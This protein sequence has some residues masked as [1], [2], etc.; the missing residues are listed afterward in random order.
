[1]PSSSPA[2]GSQKRKAAD[3]DDDTSASTSSSARMPPAPPLHV[4]PS[5]VQASK[6]STPQD[7]S[8]STVGTAAGTSE[9]MTHL[10]RAND[11]VRPLMSN[12]TMASY[13][14]LPQAVGYSQNAVG[15]PAHQQKQPQLQVIGHH[16]LQ[17]NTGGGKR[18]KTARACDSCR[19]KKIRCDVIEDGTAPGDPN[20]GNNGLTCAHC[21]QYGFETRFK[22]KREREREAELAAKAGITGDRPSSIPGSAHL[23]SPYA[24]IPGMAGPSA[25]HLY[26]S[27]SGHYFP[28]NVLPPGTMA[29]SNLPPT[30]ARHIVPSPS[31]SLSSGLTS[32]SGMLGPSSSAPVRYPSYDSI[33]S[34]AP[35][36]R[37]STQEWPPPPPLPMPASGAMA[38][39][40]GSASSKDTLLGQ[41]PAVGDVRGPKTTTPRKDSPRSA[42]SGSAQQPPD[43]RVLGPTSIAYIV[44][45]Q[46]FMP[47]A[48]IEAHDIKHHQTFEIGASGDG[49][50]KFNRP[51][52]RASA[53]TS[54]DDDEM[55]ATLAT[56]VAIVAAAED[57]DGKA[58]GMRKLVGTDAHQSPNGS[59]AIPATGSPSVG[60]G[61]A[62]LRL[63]RDVAENLANVYFSKIANMFPVVTKAE[64]LHLSPPPPLLLY[65]VCSI[66]ALS[67]EVPREVLL[68]VKTALASIFRET[69]V[70]STS[71]SVTVRALLILSLH[72]DVHGST[73]MQ[74]GA[75]CWNRTGCAVRMAQDLGLHR[76]ATGRDDEDDDR[77]FLEQ[78]RRI[79]GCCV[80][81]DRILS[82]SLGHPLAID[83]TE[84]DVRLPSPYE[85]KRWDED[86]S[87]DPTTDRPF[88]FN[89]E[90][91]KLSILFGRV[92]KTIYSPTGLMKT[93]DEEITG[94]LRDIDTWREMLPPELQFQGP[95]SPPNAGVLHVAFAALQT[96]FWR[97]FLR[98]SYICPTHLKFSLNIE[99]M[100]LLMRW[101]RE[102]IEWVDR[103]DF[104]LDTLQLVSYSLVFCATIQY[105]RWV[106]RG[107]K[108]GL[109]TLKL[110]RDCV[111]RFKRPDGDEREDLSMRAKTAGVISML[112]EAASGVFA[113]S[114]LGSQLN[115]TA[116]VS[117]RRAVDTLRGIVFRADPNRPG[118]G[119]YVA[120][121]SELILQDLPKGTI[122]HESSA[123]APKADA[124]VNG[125]NPSDL[126]GAR[127]AKN[128]GWNGTA[129]GAG[130]ESVG[131]QGGNL[132]QRR[133]SRM[134]GQ[135]LMLD[136]F[137][138]FQI[139]PEAGMGRAVT[140]HISDNGPIQ[141][142]LQQPPYVPPQS[143]SGL[144][145]VLNN[146]SGISTSEPMASQPDN[147]TNFG[148]SAGGDF[149]FSQNGMNVNPLLN[150]LHWPTQPIMLATGAGLEG[151]NSVSFA[152]SSAAFPAMPNTSMPASSTALANGNVM[153]S[154]SSSADSST[155]FAPAVVPAN[156]PQGFFSNNMSMGLSGAEGAGANVS[157]DPSVL[158]GLPASGL[159][160]GAWDNFFSRFGHMFPTGDGATTSSTD[161]NLAGSTGITVS[162]N[163][164]PL[165]QGDVS[166]AVGGGFGTGPAF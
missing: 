39:S 53:A 68:C 38:S 26:R 22:K 71:K 96:L 145:G 146:T 163:A 111:T 82:I 47:G 127:D 156:Q 149:A 19:R 139:P 94:L 158:D 29:A 136:G 56:D 141:L 155:I 6:T 104:Y 124:D 24:P 89:T 72:S 108:Q 116:G 84:C 87:A 14:H 23:A 129:D 91:L 64:F 25:V 11:S 58:D 110:C 164:G 160:F 102:G 62:R 2:S 123:D 134:L 152:P 101:T 33:S 166:A 77:F 18:I 28:A 135:P 105:H 80:T 93:T 118:G 17:T 35:V 92:M 27:A 34:S 103:N 162:G 31:T 133:L 113:N 161:N 86:P 85:V 114:P 5:Y 159:D 36:A 144:S 21:R 8:P 42:A 57:G 126:S 97:V 109:E 55:E 153:P 66:A 130:E 98:I 90:M 122:I 107:E 137:T 48:A 69:D 121:N 15:L 100:T 44:H 70:L 9:D 132:R 46:P 1:M 10:H 150:E 73:A 16:G 99:R 151:F 157:L 106:R 76:D 65:A 30:M 43:A 32:T 154:G 125:S 138:S 115:P 54:G 40:Y 128:T 12:P 95:E 148:I 81:A 143:S 78:K 50:I 117:N 119:V 60:A 20:N 67:R 37:L 45:S 4:A 120:A 83:L 59:I 51:P 41:I 63:A 75:R 88:A 7:G 131:Q 13:G 52:R 74:S 3:M 49:I 140:A 165:P 61:L 147:E 112:Y 142:E 79:W